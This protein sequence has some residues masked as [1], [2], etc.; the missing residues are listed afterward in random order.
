MAVVSSSQG[1]VPLPFVGLLI[2]DV[3]LES[4]PDWRYCP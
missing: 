4:W 2:R 1:E 3:T